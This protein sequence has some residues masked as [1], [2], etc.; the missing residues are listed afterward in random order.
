METSV[1]KWETPPQRRTPL[2]QIPGK[3]FVDKNSSEDSHS[4]N[5]TGKISYRQDARNGVAHAEFFEMCFLFHVRQATVKP[6][7][8]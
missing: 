4:R 8:L 2:V 1:P 5:F 6:S 3:E 7:P